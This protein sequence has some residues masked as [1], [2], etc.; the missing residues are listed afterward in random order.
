M[1]GFVLVNECTHPD[2]TKDKVLAMTAALGFQQ[3]EL[4]SWWQRRTLLVLQADTEAAAPTGDGWTLAKIVD[5]LDDPEALAYHTTQNGRPLILIGANVILASAAKG[6]DWILGPTGLLPATSHEL[7]ET[8]VDP[9]CDWVAPF[10]AT[11]WLPIEVCDSV[12]G[13][14]YAIPAGG[15]YLSNFVGP[16]Y[17]S[18]G[19]GPYDRMGLCTSPR[20]LRP[21]G[22]QQRIVG[23]PAG[24]TS[25]VWGPDMPLWKRLAK[26]KPGTRFARIAGRAEGWLAEAGRRL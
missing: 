15:A 1:D 20:E 26:T 7:G 24:A 16:R 14:T 11:S 10:D 21:G 23:G 3:A 25:T 2:L 5:Q 13:D 17:F 9:Y 12:E 18:S 4:A 19:P 22:Y 6:S 8:A